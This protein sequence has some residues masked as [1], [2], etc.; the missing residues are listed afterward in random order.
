MTGRGDAMAQR[1]KAHE[2]DRALGPMPG[3]GRRRAIR[4]FAA[5]AGVG[6]SGLAQAGDKAIAGRDVTVWRWQGTALGAEAELAVAHPEP[7]AAKRLVGLALNEVKR[8]EAIFSLYRP[9]S[10]LVR[11]NTQGQIEHPPLEL[12]E[13]LSRAQA[14]SRRTDGAFDVTVQPLWVLYSGHF[15]RDGASRDGPPPRELAAAA[16]L[17]DYRRLEVAP[18]RIRLAQPGMAVTL[19]GIAQGY[20]TDRVADL[21]RADGLDR[22]LVSLGEMRAVG[23][24]ADGLPWRVG[25]QLPRRS[26][27]LQETVELADMAV[28]TS[29][30]S[31]LRFDPDGRFH[32]LFDPRSGN[33][34]RGYQ[35]ASVVAERACDADALSTALVIAGRLGLSGDAALSLGVARISVVEG[36]G[37]HRRLL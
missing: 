15:S 19:N 2:S 27:G 16:G 11:L 34:A 31:G 23:R 7:A 33:C 32:H 1:D 29:S 18:D 24:P 37:S 3:I 36:D 26:G 20:I 21:L 13:V 9:E 5:A 14:W 12:V 4:L 22:V 17:V 8:L 10:A 35:S 28:A 30:V 25:L 6:F